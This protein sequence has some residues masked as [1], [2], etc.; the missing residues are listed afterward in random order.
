M[1]T[2]AT[3]EQKIDGLQ[4]T[5]SIINDYEANSPQ[6][7]IIHRTKRHYYISDERIAPRPPLPPPPPALEKWSMLPNS[8]TCR[9]LVTKPRLY[10]KRAWFRVSDCRQIIE[11]GMVWPL[12]I[13]QCQLHTIF[14]CT[15]RVRWQGANHSSATDILNTSVQNPWLY[16]WQNGSET[17][18]AQHT[19]LLP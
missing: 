17:E 1:R 12:P 15:A 9:F 4:T 11:S 13:F 14:Q 7:T 3:S 6:L 18:Y 10:Q 16:S 19:L 5:C 2:V 8:H